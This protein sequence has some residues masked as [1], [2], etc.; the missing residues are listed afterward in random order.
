MIT[1]PII[2]DEPPCCES[3]DTL[4]ERYCPAVK[5]LDMLQQKLAY[6]L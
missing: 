4:P 6:A 1:A 2:V 5:V 3:L